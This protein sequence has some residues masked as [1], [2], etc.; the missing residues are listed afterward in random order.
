ME[1]D[2]RGLSGLYNLGNTCYMNAT[3]QC[4]FATDTLN[5]YLKGRKFK[6]D[7]KNGI[8]NLEVEKN[9][10]ILKLNPHISIEELKEY[11]KTKKYILKLSFKNS[12]TYS[13]YKVF[14]MMWNINCVVKP[15][16]LKD[17]IGL[18]CPKFNNFNQHDSEEFIYSILDRLH[19]ETK[20][21]INIKNY[22]VSSEVADY[23]NKRRTLLK[24]I[25][26]TES[27]IEKNNYVSELNDLFVNNYNFEV[28][29]KSI[30]YWKN[31]LKENHSVI[32]TIFSGLYMSEIK[33]VSCNNLNI[34]FEV[35]NIL[36]IPLC[37][38]N[39]NNFNTLEECISH[40][41]Q[42]ESVENYNCDNCKIKDTIAKKKLTI[43]QLPQKLIIQLKRFTTRNNNNTI[44]RFMGNSKNDS[45]IKFPITNLDLSIAQSSIKPLTTK[46]NLYGIVNHSGNLNGGHYTAYCKNLLDKNWYDFND[47]SV[48]YVNNTNELIDSSAYILFYER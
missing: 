40:F 25:K 12:V 18:Y 5:C 2:T 27:D 23:Y 28:I 20:T 26:L 21:S 9:R 3:I 10:D 14:I 41:C 37:D 22:K 8:I 7:L 48:S 36:E 16:T 24:K 42:E 44:M 19:E 11:I 6:N 31:Y 39:N 47:S 15:K 30:E 1:R 46:Y 17:A 34:N 45:L 38:D 43:F 29:V 13:M 35:F 33:C 4:L 32:S